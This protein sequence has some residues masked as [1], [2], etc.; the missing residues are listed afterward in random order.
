MRIFLIMC[1]SL[2]T[3]SVSVFA[4]DM[5]EVKGVVK[6]SHNEPLI[7][8]SIS[9]SNKAGLGTTTNMNGEYKIKVEQY[10]KLIFSYVGF[11]KQEILVKDQH[12]IDVTLVESDASALTEVVITGTGV[13]QKATVTG[14][15]TTVNTRDLKSNPTG[16]I[17]NA[18]AGNVP[19]VMAMQTS[20][21]PG[22]TSE[23]WIRGI[24]T[25]GASSKAL[26]LVD[27]FERNLDEINVEDI[28][29]FSVLKDASATAIYGSRGANG[30]VIITTKRGESGKIKINA[31]LET[32]YNTLT[33]VPKFVD[34]YRYASLMNEARVTRNEEPMLRPDEM[35][36][37]RLGLDPDLYPNVNWKDQLLK[38]GAMSGR[39]AVDL[40]GGGNTARYFVSASYFDQEGIYKVDKTMKD[41]NTNANYRRWN[42]RMNTDIDITKTTVLEVGVSGSLEKE[43]DTGLSSDFLWESIMYYNPILTPVMYS[44]GK[45]PAYGTGKQTNPYVLATM[46]GYREGWK[47]NIQTNATLKQDLNFVTEG[48]RFVGRFGYDTNNEN[49]IHRTKHPEQW[50]A[51]RF[52]NIMTHEIEYKRVVEAQEMKQASS[53]SGNRNEFLEAEFHY[54][55]GFGNHNIGGTAKY[56][57]SSKVMTVNLGDDLK[58]G[59]ALRN[60]SIAGRATYR[61]N[62]RYF[63]EFNFGYTGSE[64]FADGHQFGFFPAVSG[65]W[66]IADEPFIKNKWGNWLELFKVRYSWGKV[67]N[68]NLGDQNRFPY[69][70]NLERMGKWEGEGDS[71]HWEH[72]GGYDFGDYNFSN[73]YSGRRYKQVASPYVTWEMATK[74]NLG[75]DISLFGDKFSATIDY[76]DEKR[77]GIFMRRDFLSDMVG[78]EVDSEKEETKNATYSKANVGKVTSKGFDGNF[79]FHQKVKAVDITLRGNITFSH[80]KT[81]ERDEENNYYTYRLWKGYRVNQAW[82][83]IDEGL[84][85]DWDDIRNSPKQDFG[86]RAVMPGDIKYKDVNGDGVIDENDEVAIGSTTKPNMIYGFGASATWN[87]LD[88]NLHFQGAGKS[89]FF[90]DGATVHMFSSGQWGNVLTDI[91]N[92]NRWVSADISGDP[93][94]ENPNADY[95]RLSFG[96]NKNNF[97]KSTYWQRDGSYLR[98]KTVEVGY[99][100]P[101][102]LVNKL[103]ISNVRVFFIGTNLLTWSNFKLW[104]PEMSSS[105]GIQYPKPQTYSLGLSVN[106]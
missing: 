86:G 53:G 61:W 94:T 104:D 16:S 26:V 91:A 48:L 7:G 15:I 82:G 79:A 34:G 73:M 54:D 51:E 71:K 39:V 8:V 89:T 4:Q 47:N 56:T 49:N 10:S 18:L 1:V 84:F 35:D 32:A 20:G 106:I 102:H 59:I 40:Q 78:L 52:R 23:F 6:D 33:K 97:R 17:S 50:K 88:V 98:L 27:G 13:Q 65:A 80:N 63:A 3:F 14:A 66:N 45:V 11:D 2:L 87:G 67:G 42:Y 30:V 70:Y 74:H 100:L 37:L 96:E 95:P 81:I 105:N 64:N 25:F 29:S 90:I 83:L 60:Q 44:D 72:A 21:K 85:K 22:S 12:V 92:S 36:I 101:K 76:F 68:D 103:S 99:T 77:D 69:L 46:T 75:L 55:R 19:G 62:Y 28:E 41:Y 24:S 9:I 58:N 57:Q 5:V 31:K 38:D 43:N 93:S